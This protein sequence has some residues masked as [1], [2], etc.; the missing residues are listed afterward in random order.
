MIF[1]LKGNLFDKLNE[2]DAIVNTV[3][4]VGVM[5][6][7]I[8]LEFK[9]RFPDNTKE[10]VTRCKE[11]SITIGNS[12]V[13]ELGNE[14]LTK[15][16]VNFPTKKHWRNP[17]KIEY[18]DAGLEDLIKIIKQYEI[19]SIAL[20]ALGAGL[21]GLNWNEVKALISNKL[22]FLED[23]EIY[24]YEPQKSKKLESK[25]KKI[26]KRPTLTSDR[27]KLLLLVDYYNSKS[28]SSLATYVQI[29]Q[30]SYLLNFNNEKINFK[31]FKLG[32]YSE[33]ITKILLRL[34]NH[35]LVPINRKKNDNQ[36]IAVQLPTISDQKEIFNS[37]EM[38][39]V[40]SLLKDFED[41]SSLMMLSVCHWIMVDRFTASFEENKIEYCYQIV[42]T[43]FNANNLDFDSQLTMRALRRISSS[44]TNYENFSLDL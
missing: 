8:A 41:E 3:N 33:E 7:G 35:Y 27:K 13:F 10:Y 44:Y 28:E 38:K 9:K 22:E 14:S 21:G 25:E 20:P 37:K 23:V 12:F 5:G 31:L 1:F 19:K 11:G 4:T 29:H 2:V 36:M 26:E 34:N 39:E 32:P 16:I 42:E 30:L 40:I 15:F 6:K 43:W 17:S 18:V 24:V